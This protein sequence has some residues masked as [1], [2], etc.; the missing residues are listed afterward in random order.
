VSFREKVTRYV[1][2][3]AFNGMT[4]IKGART[5]VTNAYNKAIKLKELLIAAEY[6]PAKLKGLA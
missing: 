5:Y 2:N 6:I 3:P 4:D 1:H